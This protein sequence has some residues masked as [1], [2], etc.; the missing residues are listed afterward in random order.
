MFEFKMKCPPDTRSFC[1]DGQRSAAADRQAA[2]S[3]TEKR[4][5]AAERRAKVVR[6]HVVERNG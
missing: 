4:A 3:V 2:L 1:F 6:R 5:L